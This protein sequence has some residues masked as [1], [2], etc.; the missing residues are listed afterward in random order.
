MSTVKVS[1]RGQLVIPMEIRKRYGIEAGD[2]VELLDFGDQIVMIPIKD[3]IEEA[4]GWL[5]S[6]QSVAQMLKEAREEEKIAEKRMT[7]KYG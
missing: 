3:A 7:E 5:R 1:T 2:E 6:D 4:E